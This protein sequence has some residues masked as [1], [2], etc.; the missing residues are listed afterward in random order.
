M[1]LQMRSIKFDGNTPAATG[2]IYTREAGESIVQQIKERMV[3]SFMPIQESLE[4]DKVNET[5]PVALMN[6]MIGKVTGSTLS[7]D[8]F[9]ELEFEWIKRPDK[10][11]IQDMLETMFRDAPDKVDLCPMLQVD[12]RNVK[13][14]FNI[15]EWFFFYMVPDKAAEPGDVLGALGVQRD[16]E[17]DK[18]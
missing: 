16:K 13:V 15:L 14:T 10:K 8:G 12:K 2:T 11:Q 5:R 7:A 3:K 17:V 6:H 18:A 4:F 9:L 1:T